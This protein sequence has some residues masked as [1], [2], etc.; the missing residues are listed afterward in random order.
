MRTALVA[1]AT[2]F[3]LYAA[4]ARGD[5]SGETPR[6]PAFVSLR[7]AVTFISSCLE[8]AD[9]ATLAR[10]CLDDGG[11]LASAV[12]TQLQ[13]AH[14]EVP[15]GTRYEKREFPADAETFTLGGHGS[16]LGHI[17]IDFVKRSG[18]WRISRIWMCR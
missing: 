5:D 10:A 6:K 7:E 14:K 13:Q 18:K 11:S 4:Q 16:E 9:R 3:L 15:F 1:V 12:F 2:L 17:H 8:R